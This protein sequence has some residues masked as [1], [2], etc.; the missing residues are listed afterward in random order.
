[1]RY[2]TFIAMSIAAIGIITAPAATA[3]ASAQGDPDRGR[4]KAATCMG[5]HG[6]PGYQNVYPSYTVPRLGG[7]HAQYIVAALE[8][9]KNGQRSHKTMQAQAAS[10][11]T[12]DMQD[13]AEYFASAKRR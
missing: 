9:Y 8:A 13:I 7:Q 6:I 3:Q 12:E 11:S 10:L 5:C 1:M 4:A 2:K